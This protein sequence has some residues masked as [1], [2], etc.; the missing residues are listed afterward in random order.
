MEA[1]GVVRK[2]LVDG[3][4]EIPVETGRVAI[5]VVAIQAVVVVTGDEKT[6]TFHNLTLLKSRNSGRYL[7]KNWPETHASQ[8][9]VI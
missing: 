6:S 5:P 4:A 9:Y 3:Q 7:M 2:I 1:T 8:R